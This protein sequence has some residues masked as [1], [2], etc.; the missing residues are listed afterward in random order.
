MQVSNSVLRDSAK[1]P[2]WLL[3]FGLCFNFWKEAY[4]RYR[5][6]YQ[7]VRAT[8]SFALQL[9]VIHATE[10]TAAME[11]LSAIGKHHEAP[12][13]LLTGAV[14]DFKLAMENL[15]DAKIDAIAN[16]FDNLVLLDDFTNYN[17]FES[18]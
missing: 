15:Q 9:G 12:S 18:I 10:A 4:V 16:Q 17:D 8:L 1:D 7:V 5:V 11:E 6:I 2:H 13:Q 14:M 3:Y